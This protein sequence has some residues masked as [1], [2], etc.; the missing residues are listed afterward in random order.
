MMS[1]A[2][3]P[4]VAARFDEQNL[5]EMQNYEVFRGECSIVLLWKESKTYRKMSDS[6][7]ERREIVRSSV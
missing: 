3:V 6:S 2:L 5:Y 1:V 4:L 7:G